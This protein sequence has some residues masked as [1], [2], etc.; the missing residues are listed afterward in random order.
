MSI[1]LERFGSEGGFASYDPCRTGRPVTA[2]F[3]VQCR[4]CGFEPA[5]QAVTPPSV[6]PKCHGGAWE[7]FARPGSIL[8]HACGGDDS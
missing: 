7:R 8:D 1:Q 4:R 2:V 5:D 6:C 3:H